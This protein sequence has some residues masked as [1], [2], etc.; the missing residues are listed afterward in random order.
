MHS[1][2]IFLVNQFNPFLPNL[3]TAVL[4]CWPEAAM[5][6][7]QKTDSL[8]PKGYYLPCKAHNVFKFR[9]EMQN[10]M[11]MSS[12]LIQSLLAGYFLIT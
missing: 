9:K 1:E 4:A 3:D 11:V 5:R 7:L 12:M 10:W 2:K 6:Q 8:N